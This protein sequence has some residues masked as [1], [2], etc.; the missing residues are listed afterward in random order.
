MIDFMPGKKMLI[1]ALRCLFLTEMKCH[2]DEGKS[3]TTLRS[4][5]IPIFHI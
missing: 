3:L 4:L 1:I 5:S 2:K